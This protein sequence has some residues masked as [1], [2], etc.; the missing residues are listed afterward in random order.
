MTPIMVQP[1]F[2]DCGGLFASSKYSYGVVAVNGSLNEGKMVIL[3]T[4]TERLTIPLPP[5]YT[6]QSRTVSSLNFNLIP[7]CDIGG[8]ND[9]SFQYSLDKNGSIVQSGTVSC[10]ILHFENLESSSIYVVS[11][12]AINDAGASSWVSASYSTSTGI[13]K[14]P[15]LRLLK[16]NTFSFLVDIEPPVDNDREII[17]YTFNVFQ[18]EQLITNSTI[19]CND[20]VGP[21]HLQCGRSVR[22]DNLNRNTTYNVTVLALGPFGESALTSK[23]VLT[24]NEERGVIEFTRPDYYAM[25]GGKINVTLQRK[26]GA[27]GA[28]QLGINVTQPENVFLRCTCIDVSG[29]FCGMHITGSG[30]QSVAGQVTFSDGQEF[31][32]VIVSVWEDDRSVLQPLNVLLSLLGPSNYFGSQKDTILKIDLSQRPGFASFI[33]SKAEVFENSTHVRVNVIRLNGSSGV[34][35]FQV[36]T[37]DISA[38][39]MKDYVPYNK[40]LEFGD[41]QSQLSVWIKLINNIFYEGARIF[42]IRLRDLSGYTKTAHS[43]VTRQVIIMDDEDP[44]KSLPGRPGSFEVLRT[45][46]G[47]IE[48]QWKHPTDIDQAYGYL[49]RVEEIGSSGFFNLYNTSDTWFVLS[50]L[51]PERSYK[52]TLSAWNIYGTGEEAE[53]IYARTT[54][55]SP[56][57]APQLFGAFEVSSSNISFGWAP[58]RDSGGVPITGYLL[59]MESES[60]NITLYQ[61]WNVSTNFTLCGLEALHTYRFHIAASTAAFSASFE[62]EASTLVIV[63]DEATVPDPPNSPILLSNP[64]AGTFS[65]K[66]VSS[67]N[68]GGIKLTGYTLYMRKVIADDL[69]L[70][71]EEQEATRGPFQAVCTAESIQVDDVPQSCVVYKLHAGTSYEFYSKV[72][73]VLVSTVL[74]SLL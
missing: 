43:V 21:T 11:I 45:T 55:P 66:T 15:L 38:T 18:E 19:Q 5:F 72:H 13:P 22:F 50:Q 10:C 47:E 36:E 60:K 20:T 8:S 59:W 74:R 26:F 64:T 28:M 70:N 68:T 16:T 41:R 53:S 6:L 1:P 33:R 63:M 39:A 67:R 61:S 23:L 3:N 71:D 46:G 58:P 40:S 65:I 62:S 2:Y 52:I 48:L 49:L 30:V 14:K 29:C 31:Q 27:A 24:S 25:S 69:D 9:V 57:T 4:W 44:S 12:R 35:P 51:L 73:N 37:F 17:S 56:P 54:D 7:H 42:G 34:L 32:T